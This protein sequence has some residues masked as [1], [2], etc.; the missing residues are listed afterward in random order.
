MA[1]KDMQRWTG[2]GAGFLAP[3]ERMLGLVESMDRFFGSPWP[4]LSGLSTWDPKLS[5]SESPKGFTISAQLPGVKKEDLKVD[6]TDNAVTIQAS[7]EEEDS[8]QGRKHVRLRRRSSRSFYHRLTLPAE[9]RAQEV[10]A[11]FKEGEL[12]IELPRARETETRRIDI[13]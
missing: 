9:I 3:F 13:R 2:R 11:S 5:L 4:S 7:H 12:K 6:V 1:D 10:R 8:A